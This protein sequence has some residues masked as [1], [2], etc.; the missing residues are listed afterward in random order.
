MRRLLT[1]ALTALSLCGGVQ[2]QTNEQLKQML[3]QA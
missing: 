1:L 2:A 3:D